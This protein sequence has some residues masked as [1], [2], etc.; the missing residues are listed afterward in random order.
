MAD[1]PRKAPA[2]P[3]KDQRQHRATFARDKRNPGGYLV[4]VVGP[5]ATAFAGRQVPVTRADDTESIETL[6]VAVWAGT[7]EGMPASEGRPAIKGTG[8]PVALYQFAARERDAQ[9]A[10]NLPF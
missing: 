4:R 6:T 10:D 2:I 1:E 3:P 5:H 7:D 8:Q 9:A